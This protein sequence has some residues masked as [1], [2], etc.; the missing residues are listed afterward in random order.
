MSAGRL[1]AISKKRQFV[2]DGVLY[3]ELNEL[4]IRE[5]GPIGYAGVEVRNN[6]SRTEIVIRATR[7]QDVLGEKG[8]KIRELN[9]VVEKRFKFKPGTVTL[10]AERVANRGLSAE[11]QAESLAAKLLEG[12]AVRRACY[13]IIRLVMKNE[14]KGVECLVT[15]KLRGARAKAMKFREGYMIKTGNSNREYVDEAVRHVLLRQGAVGVKVK[16]MKPHDPEGRQG[17]KNPLSDI[18]EVMEPKAVDQPNVV[19]VPSRRPAPVEPVAAAPVVPAG[20][21]AQFPGATFAQ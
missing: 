16:I 12:M 20:D 4:L 6:P 7:P 8:R 19:G 1:G 5:L 13:G 9:T 11:A 3:A 2:A 17:P 18:V 21:V 15:G 14:A 10:Y